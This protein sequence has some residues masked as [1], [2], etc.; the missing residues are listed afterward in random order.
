MIAQKCI[1]VNLF[2]RFFAVLAAVYL[3]LLGG[4][5]YNVCIIIKER[6]LMKKLVAL[7]LT[8]ALCLCAV[9]YTALAADPA[10]IT[11]T[12]TVT[13]NGNGNYT[14]TAA[15]PANISSGKIVVSTSDRLSLVEDS[16]TSPIGGAANPYYER[17]DVC[18][19]VVSF[20][21]LSALPEG[22]IAFS[23]NYVAEDGAEIGTEDIFVPEWGVNDGVE[24][25]GTQNDGD[26]IYVFNEGV[27][28]DSSDSSDSSESSDSSDIPTGDKP[29]CLLTLSHLGGN[30][31]NITMTTVGKTSSGKAVVAVSDNL[32]LVS[33]SLKTY[34]G[35]AVNE[36]YA[37]GDVT[38]AS[39]TYATVAVLPTGTLVFSAD[40]TAAEGAEISLADVD[41]P[42]WNL[43]LDGVRLSSNLDTELVY[44]YVAH[45]HDYGTQWGSDEEFHW[46]TCACGYIDNYVVHDY[47][48]D[49]DVDCNTCGYQR[50]P[51]GLLG[52]VDGD[53]Y[54]DN[55]DASYILKYDAGI[56]DLED[57]AL[58]C[59]DVDFDGFV[60]NTDASY[61]LKYDA[62]IIPELGV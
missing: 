24:W 17:G 1:F 30:K 57:K 22:S 40:Y 23:A 14:V 15:L 16:L 4:L 7:I 47:S 36:N 8:A 46:Q 53:G 49:C 11:Y 37:R 2:K 25:L 61:I 10:P 38:G 21:M 54:V 60:D 58:L 41:V 50:E 48:N 51:L 35:G 20:A 9:G 13:N 62:G 55:T 59:G 56:I 45:S 26:V 27:T 12:L 31:Y 29:T 39:V 52:D 18:G 43:S 28:S 6:P 33:G 5:R 42:E 3:D 34:L 44:E 19:A 32:S